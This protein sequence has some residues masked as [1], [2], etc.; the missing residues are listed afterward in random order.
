MMDLQNHDNKNA[1]RSDQEE[2][3]GGM[4]HDRAS[5]NANYITTTTTNTSTHIP[6]LASGNVIIPYSAA[7]TNTRISED[8]LQCCCGRRD[9]AYLKHNNVALG[10]LEKDLE[11]AARLGQVCHYSDTSI[12]FSPGRLFASQYCR[13]RFSPLIAFMSTKSKAPCR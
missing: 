9:C 4:Q 6:S 13:C 12:F 5:T 10:D 8:T 3:G 2:R 11:T 7:S 1:N